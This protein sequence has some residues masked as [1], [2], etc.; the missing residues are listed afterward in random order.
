[1]DRSGFRAL[2]EKYELSYLASQF[3]ALDVDPVATIGFLGEFSAGKSTLINGLLGTRL[4]PAME[5]P[6]TGNV[7]EVV[8]SDD[9]TEMSYFELVGGERAKIS[10]MDFSDLA[11]GTRPGRALVEVPPTGLLR[12]GFRIVDTPG[13]ESLNDTHGD[14][15][16][17]YLPYLDAVVLCLNRHKG[18]LSAS[19][20]EF[21]RRPEL[22]P[23]R[24]RVVVAVTHAL[25]APVAGATQVRDEVVK[26]LVPLFGAGTGASERVVLCDAEAVLTGE[27]AEGLT[28][29]LSTFEST[30]VARKRSMAAHRTAREERRLGEE[31]LKAVDQFIEDMVLDEQD[32]ETRKIEVHQELDDLRRQRTLERARIDEFAD[33]LRAAL[34]RVAERHRLILQDVRED[35]LDEA[36]A[37]FSVELDERTTA[38]FKRYVEDAPQSG[39]SSA[40]GAVRARLNT[41][42]KRAEFGKT[43]VTAAILAGIGGGTT[44]AK[45]AGEATVGAAAREA[46]KKGA[47]KEVAKRMLFVKFVS[48]LIDKV[49]PVNHLG[50]WAADAFKRGMLPSLLAQT[51][52]SIVEDAR[53]DL[54]SSLEREVFAPLE[55]KIRD[56]ERGLALLT[57]ERR[58]RLD[59]WQRLKDEAAKDRALLARHT[60]TA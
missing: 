32:I 4:L 45:N 22:V 42:L 58:G 24:D 41:I 23:L 48:D 40:A 36:M 29:F 20:L 43:V 18:G 60:G 49:N 25:Q 3:D 15:T 6:T 51:V 47:A 17:G 33:E 21:L 7:V 5:S 30:V 54:N 10:Y 46:A 11:I 28:G 44:V 34:Q 14:I 27:N 39:A 13:L 37:A 2:A 1:M 57:S 50:D 16:F 31:L 53:G 12:S 38:L 26:S 59:E 19:A 9:A 8:P 52:E 35:Q 55:G 56:R